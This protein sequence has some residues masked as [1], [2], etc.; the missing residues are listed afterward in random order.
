MPA[1]ACWFESG[2]GHQ[3]DEPWGGAIDAFSYLSVLISIVLGFALTEVLRGLVGVVRAR[4]RAVIYWP[5]L[6]WAVFSVGAII[7]S[8][9]ASFGLR[10]HLAWTF[11]D[12]TMVLLQTALL[13]VFTALVLPDAPRAGEDGEPELDLRAN[14][15]A[16]RRWMF[17]ALIGLV[18]ASLAKD[19]VIDGVLPEPAN[20][21]FHA[22]LAM[23][24]LGAAI[25]AREWYHWAVALTAP[26]ALVVYIAA[27]FRSLP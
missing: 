17:G 3:S 18:A 13:Y 14:Y 6:A 24:A 8:W 21:A 16:H 11:G 9:W 15:H 7:Q 20:L 19:L 25:T 23:T 2:L 12:F 26:L 22:V 27:L 10:G 5:A 1:T 4:K